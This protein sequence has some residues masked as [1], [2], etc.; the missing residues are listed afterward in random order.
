L[1]R[2]ESELIGKSDFDHNPKEQAEVFWAMDDEVFETRQENINIEKTDNRWGETRWVESRKSY[3][4][5]SSGEPYIIGVLTDITKLEEQKRLIKAAELKAREASISKSQFLANMSHEIRT[6]MNGIMGMSELLLTSELNARQTDFA[7]IINRSG[8]ALLTIIND[9]LDFSKAEAGKIE[10][11]IQP[12][13]LRNCIEDVTALLASTIT[14]TGLDLLVRIQPG[15][16]KMFMGDAGRIRQVLTNIIIAG[17]NILIID[18]NP[19]N[20]SILKE[21]LSH[22]RCES[23]AVESS[24]LGLA[25]LQKAFEKNIKIDLII[26]DYQMPGQNG[27]DFYRAKQK[28]EAFADIPVIMLSSIDSCELRH[29]MKSLD[30]NGFITKPARSSVLYDAIADAVCGPIILAEKNTNPPDINLTARPS[31]LVT[32][33]HVDVLIAEDNEVNQIYASY[34]MEELGLTFETAPNGK[35]AVEKW[36]QLSPKAVLMDISMPEMNGYEATQAIRDIEKAQG[37]TPTLI[38]A[39]TAHSMQGDKHA[40][41]KNGMDDYLSKP[42]AIKALKQCLESWDVLMNQSSERKQ[43]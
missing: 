20:R 23:A 10:L 17:S 28:R 33:K 9:I 29:R 35:I 38:I 24:Q 36:Q 6:P 37:L 41:L 31:P 16:P 8:E 32:A 22:W 39:V 1:G 19:I 5:T 27:E 21:Q 26:L 15:L 34:V 13:H 30:I 40:C 7:N 14:E 25:V 3:Y 18:D 43:A 12:F 42:L 11:D 4:E 2:E